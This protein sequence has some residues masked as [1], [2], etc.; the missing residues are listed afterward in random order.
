MSNLR[1]SIVIKLLAAFLVAGLLM[2][3]ALMLVQGRLHFNVL[4][5]KQRVE[6]EE[7][8]RNASDAI[9]SL[10]QEYKNTITQLSYVQ[11]LNCG[12]RDEVGKTLKNYLSRSLQGFV[13]LYYVDANDR[14]YSSS[15]VVLETLRKTMNYDVPLKLAYSA[16]TN[17]AAVIS[18]VYRSSMITAN[19]VAV[20]RRNSYGGVAIGELG[21]DAI[22]EQIEMVCGTWDVKY[23]LLS[24]SSKVIFSNLPKS[25]KPQDIVDRLSGKDEGWT[26]YTSED[27]VRYR[28][29]SS[30]GFRRCD[31]ELVIIVDE[32]SVYTSLLMLM[33]T[34]LAVSALLMVCMIAVLAVIA[35]YFIKP[36]RL[37]SKSIQSTE[38]PHADIFLNEKRKDEIGDL[39]RS[40]GTMLQHI[41][42]MTE[43][44][45]E[46][47]KKRF[48]AEKRALQNQIAPHFLYNSL[49]MLSSLAM[50]GGQDRIPMAVSALVHL[51]LLSTEKTAPYDTLG[52]EVKCASEYMDIMRLRYEKKYELSINVADDLK[53]L[54]VIKLLLLPII[55]NSVYHGLVQT[56]REGLVIIE[57]FVEDDMLMISVM[58]NGCGM[59][60]HKAE[61]LLSGD[62]DSEIRSTG[63]VNTDARIKLYFGDEYGLS[64][65]SKVGIGTRIMI[66]LP[67]IHTVDEWEAKSNENRI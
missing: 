44:Q 20:S 14:M 49:N 53:D 11:E 43:A 25:I 7:L 16:P 4:Y 62:Q 59:D 36:I 18:D 42:H 21:F 65:R 13:K 26:N 1:H 9:D 35:W 57:A 51:L 8:S 47:Q 39:S 54:L 10:L 12:D 66:S 24:G 61:K 29:F 15:E 50:S 34:N 6:Y 37:L 19:T 2:A 28:L 33:R 23:L 32:T 60:E 40:I 52:D 41:D 30:S 17:G 63:L 55:E 45:A 48:E 58:D 56:G 67:V 46:I 38:T 27:K 5:E 31:W 22:Q 64:V 3:F